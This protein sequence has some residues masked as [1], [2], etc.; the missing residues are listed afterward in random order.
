LREA[1]R[2]GARTIVVVRSRAASF[3]KRTRFSN[4]LGAWFMHRDPGVARACRT[5]A[6]AYRRGFEFLHAPPPDCRVIHVAPEGP[7]ATSR[8]SRDASSLERDYALGRALGIEAIHRFYDLGPRAD[9]PR[10]EPAAPQRAMASA[11]A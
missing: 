7:L 10:P 6:A 4:H 1:Y 11:I 5:A 3:V 9:A 2:R 8:T